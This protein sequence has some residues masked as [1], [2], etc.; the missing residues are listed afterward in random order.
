MIAMHCIELKALKMPVFSDDLI[1]LLCTLARPG[2]INNVVEMFRAVKEWDSGL[3]WIVQSVDDIN[4]GF[5]LKNI[6]YKDQTDF[7]VNH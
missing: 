6:I 7:P 4:G 3:F 5:Y 2:W 1:G